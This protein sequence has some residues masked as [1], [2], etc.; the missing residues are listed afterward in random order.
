[1]KT[2]SILLY[3]DTAEEE[4]VQ[5]CFDS[6]FRTSGRSEDELQVI[7]LD[8]SEKESAGESAGTVWPDKLQKEYPGSVLSVPVSGMEMAQA[9]NQG[10]EYAK[11]EYISFMLTS[12]FYGSDA[13]KHLLHVSVSEEKTKDFSESDKNLLSL[14]PVFY[15]GKKTERIYPMVPSGS[16]MINLHSMDAVPDESASANGVQLVFFAYAVRRGWMG[17]L[18]FRE[19][20]HEEALTAMLL[21]LL[22]KNEGRLFYDDSAQYVYTVPLEYDPAGCGLA[23]K[24]WWYLDSVRSFLSDFARR[25]K[26][27]YPEGLPRYLQEVICY[28]IHVKLRCNLQGEDK[29][30]MTPQE[31]RAFWEI[32]GEIFTVI[33]DDLL[34]HYGEE[35]KNQG[36]NQTWPKL[37]RALRT[38]FLRMKAE[39]QG[40][41][42]QVD[43]RDGMA[44]YFRGDAPAG[45]KTSAEGM[46]LAD[47]SKEALDIRVI[48][49]R[50]GNL[51]I[52]AFFEG[53]DFLREDSFELYGEIAGKSVKRV[54]I[55]HISVYGLLKC[56][57]VTYARKYGV[58]LEVPVEELAGQ[59]RKLT[60]YL[61][62]GESLNRLNLKFSGMNSRLLTYS[63]K[64]YWRFDHDRY[65][66]TRTGKYLQ[67]S[68]STAFGTI[69]HELLFDAALLAQKNRRMEAFTCVM[70][71]FLYWIIRPFMKKR[72]IWIT[73]DKLYK[74]GDNGEYMFRYCRDRQ[75][76]I[77][78]YYVINK[79]AID[80]RRLE[81][82]Y[83]GRILYANTWKT[84]LIALHAEVVLATHAGASTYLGFPGKLHKY[85]KDLY[86]SDNI[87]IQHG[88][89]IQKI[90][91][92]Q[93]RLYANT[94]LYC[95]AS[96]YE[97]QN[98]SH[99]VYG[100]E[101]QML[102]LTGLARYDGL[103]N[104]EQKQILI[105]P[106]WR[107]NAVQTKGVGM[108]NSHND[109]FKEMPYFRIYNALI[110]DPKLIE[111]A[112]EMGYKIIFL[113]HPA[114]SAQME[115]YD[116]NG[117]VQILPA[118]GDMS[119]EKIL[120]ESSLMVT[121]YSG[122]QFDFA[123][124]RK[125]LLYYHPA[126]LPPH[127]TEGGLIYDTMGVGPICTT[128]EEIISALC[129]YMREGCQMKEEYRERA[130][131]F[132]AY[133][134]FHSAERIWQA[135]MEFERE[136]SL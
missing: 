60:F 134:D 30:M 106:T 115:D 120:T 45:E 101:P 123:Y 104:K 92:F 79:D 112:R 20:L 67:V 18:R 105:T 103:K 113:L 54:E 125:P 38:A 68:E 122:V 52:D 61:S 118:T 102:K 12:S 114:M 87:C 71:R 129:E 16:G 56:F 33:D 90:A 119:Y 99:P 49:Y 96:P 74:A 85:F 65:M 69:R 130:D 10:M 34:Y 15:D 36:E 42:M 83:P 72:R 73:F 48:N 95:C 117:F 80:R 62:C 131:R 100:Y 59:G 70:V 31:V 14:C 17:T 21:E 7:L 57:G 77:D 8:P 22:V 6:I 25:M 89:S 58:H 27:K 128:H 39:K 76:E 78:C 82:L 132:F 63:Q 37:P 75:E 28:L 110:N 9:Y 84:R 13:W 97:V 50:A 2:L 136:N 24:K 91:H 55:Q 98:I 3:F 53:T 94:K 46:V 121:D 4:K 41:S 19:E 88:L 43:A 5:K 35:R 66:L 127:Y 81:K 126:E 108:T 133:D 47:L 116:Q 23:E 109:H 124:Q 29:Q 32:C 1:M 86:Q 44:V 135:V 51:E 26:K 93:N 111:C 107:K 40:Y 11:G 64:A